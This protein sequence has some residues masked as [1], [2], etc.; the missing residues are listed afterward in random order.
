MIRMINFDKIKKIVNIK[1]LNRVF[2][3]CILTKVNKMNIYIVIG[4]NKRVYKYISAASQDSFNPTLPTKIIDTKKVLKIFRTFVFKYNTIYS[5]TKLTLTFA[6][7]S[8]SPMA[9]VSLGADSALSIDIDFI[10]YILGCG[11]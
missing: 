1:N 7:I 6:I 4:L 3:S 10:A 2:H 5:K 8:I 9:R 11:I